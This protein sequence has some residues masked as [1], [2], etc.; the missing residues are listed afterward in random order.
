[1]AAARRQIDPQRVRRVDVEQAPGRFFA[2]VGRAGLM[3]IKWSLASE[4]S[5]GRAFADAP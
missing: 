2:S 4:L 1:L 3:L 5:P